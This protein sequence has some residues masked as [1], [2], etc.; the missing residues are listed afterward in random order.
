MVCLILFIYFFQ[1][2][3]FYFYGGIENLHNR[4]L[5]KNINYVEQTR[6][7]MLCKEGLLPHLFGEL[8]QYKIRVRDHTKEDLSLLSLKHATIKYQLLRIIIDQLT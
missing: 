5:C 1:P 3:L 6:E 2:T 7:K 4:C 8:V